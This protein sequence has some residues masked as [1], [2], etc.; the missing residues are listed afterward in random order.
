MERNMF[1]NNRVC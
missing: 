1:F